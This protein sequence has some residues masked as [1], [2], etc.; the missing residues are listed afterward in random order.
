MQS[1]RIIFVV[2]FK[3][4]KYALSFVFFYLMV[5]FYAPAVIGIVRFAIAF[6]AIFSFIFNL[7]FNIAHLKIYPEET[8]KSSS[9]GTLLSFKAVFICISICFYY[10]IL[11]LFNFDK[12]I[13]TIIIIFIVELIVQSINTSFSNILIADNEIIKGSFPWIIISSS[14][15]LLLVIGLYIY[16]KNEITLSFIY[17][18]STILHTAFL[19]PYIL[20]Y[21]ISKPTNSVIKKYLKFTYPLIFSNIAVL[22]S[23]NI[24][25]ILINFWISSEA[26]AFYYAAE[27]FSV[28][29][30]IIP[31]V[32]SLVMVSIFAKN[33]KKGN[34]EKNKRIIK[35]ITKYSCILFGA[36]ILLSFL[37]SDELILIFL[38]DV[39][40]P[41]IFVFNIL[42]LAQIFVINDVAVFTDLNARGL[43]KLFSAIK[44]IGEF[45]KTFLIIL[46]IAPNGLNLGING[47]ALAILFGNF[48]Y[49]LLIRIILWKKY[50]YGYN[51]GI[52]L[53]LFVVLLIFL[54]NVLVI[55]MI[56]FLTY[57]YLIPLF[58]ILNIF[59]YFIILYILRGIKKEDI[60]Y[61]KLMLNIKNL[62]N[63][64][65]QDLI[66]R[67]NKSKKKINI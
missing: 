57:F 53:Y 52:I 62:V 11:S 27:H 26:V 17:L 58:A 30:T 60:R 63:I 51:F 42:I 21:N 2:V 39:Y 20:R 18:L 5:L 66:T 32:I 31:N 12:T 37:Y 16:P 47:L 41:S 35:K 67:N 45:Y 48:T 25:I 13:T 49:S 10:M 19:L 7:G 4:S 24:G 6:V 40:E 9:I 8:S 56:D 36:I 23:G 38:G 54:F 3:V 61:F 64:L 15:I 43:T 50:K 14:K 59:F 44:I 1:Q 34:L 28:F 46:F 33:I 29:R 22:I 55:A 65:Y